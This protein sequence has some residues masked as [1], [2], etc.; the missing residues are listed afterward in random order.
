MKKGRFEAFSDGMFAIIITIMVLDIKAPHG[1]TFKDLLTQLP[2]IFCYLQSFWFVANYWSNHHHLVHC[3][4]K[5]T[6]SILVANLNLLF[7][8]S[9]I[10]FVTGWVS[11][12]NFAPE[13][14]IVYAIA[15][16]IPGFA[17]TILQ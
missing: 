13:P 7:F 9:L 16:L 17:W 12:S 5:V 11:E 15:L 8:L 1:N 4:E 10:P 3:V 2:T 14:V 6:G